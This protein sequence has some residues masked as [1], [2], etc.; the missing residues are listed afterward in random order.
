[1][2]GLEFGSLARRSVLSAGGRKVL[3]E[4]DLLPVAQ[5]RELFAPLLLP[6][7]ALCVLCGFKV[8]AIPALGNSTAKYGH[9]AV[10]Y[11]HP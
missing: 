4:F 10:T 9:P 8:F 2:L 6:L 1:M 3:A 7:C 11:S 5:W